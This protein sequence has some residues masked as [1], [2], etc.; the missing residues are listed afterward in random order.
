MLSFVMLVMWVKFAKLIDYTV[1]HHHVGVNHDQLRDQSSEEVKWHFF[2][3]HDWNLPYV[4]WLDRPKLYSQKYG[5]TW[6]SHPNELFKHHIPHLVLNFL[7]VSGEETWYI[8]SIPVQYSRCSVGLRSVH[9]TRHS[10]S[11]T[12]ALLNYV[13]IYLALCPDVLSC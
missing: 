10:S 1:Y 4:M 11:S 8:A 12:P 5:N 6:P 3:C 13:F 7:A 9:S 2:I